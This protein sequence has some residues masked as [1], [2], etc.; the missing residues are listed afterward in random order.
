VE[1][2]APTRPMTG[3]KRPAAV[4]AAPARAANGAAAEEWKDF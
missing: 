3:R 2:R 4:A 1:R